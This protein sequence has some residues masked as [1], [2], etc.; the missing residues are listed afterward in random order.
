MSAQ[1]ILNVVS[2]HQNWDDWNDPRSLPP[3]YRRHVDAPHVFSLYGHLTVKSLSHL[4]N[5]LLSSLWLPL[6]AYWPKLVCPF[7]DRAYSQR[8]HLN[9]HIKH[10]HS[11]TPPLFPCPFCGRV[12]TLKSPLTRHIIALHTKDPKR[13]PCKYCARP[14]SRREHLQVHLRSGCLSQPSGST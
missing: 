11:E 12:F 1:D 14:F 10:Q 4:P 8:G 7:C 6:H 13:Y 5:I 9:G 2:K 3:S